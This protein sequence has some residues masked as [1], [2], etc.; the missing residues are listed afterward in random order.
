VR[1]SEG[2]APF[3]TQAFFYETVKRLKTLAEA[4]AEELEVRRRPT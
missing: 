2:E 4:P 1:P 3:S